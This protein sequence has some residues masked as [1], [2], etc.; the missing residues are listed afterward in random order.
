MIRAREPYR[1]LEQ[2]RAMEELAKIRFVGVI[3][4]SEPDLAVMD[5][6]AAGLG[7]RHNRLDR[8]LAVV[9]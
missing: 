5:Y 7:L 1:I 4:T 2:A 6:V 8:Y 3:R 9:I